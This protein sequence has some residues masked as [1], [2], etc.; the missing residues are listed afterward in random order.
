MAA[1]LYSAAGVAKGLVVIA[2]GSDGLV[3]NL[4]GPWE[5]MIRGYASA[6]AEKGFCAVIPDYLPVTKTTSS[7]AV[8]DSMFQNMPIWQQALSDAID[9]AVMISKV[10]PKRIGLL[11][12]SLGGHLVLRLRSKA[13]VLVEFF[14]PKF[15]EIGAP[16]TLTHAQIH[17]GEKD[18]MP[19][20]AFPNA[21]LIQ[22]QLTKEGTAT[23]LCPYPHA[24][25]GFVGADP[26][27][28]YARDESRTRT[29]AFFQS[30]L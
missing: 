23:E 16:G 3:D 26:A 28:T 19:G 18:E 22:A 5:T 11:G 6:L 29:L 7:K 9:Q 14:A 30:H 27:N 25:H 13:K 24:G 15:I 20:T 8:F 21:V 12:F 17:H 4:S 2:Y 1:D 10:D